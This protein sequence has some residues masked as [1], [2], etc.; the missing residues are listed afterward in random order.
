MAEKYYTS[1]AP[2]AKLGDKGD[3]VRLIHYFLAV[4]GH[5]RCDNREKI[6]LLLQQKMRLNHS[7]KSSALDMKME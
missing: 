2:I 6:R 1:T 7:K 4:T 3:V 5:T